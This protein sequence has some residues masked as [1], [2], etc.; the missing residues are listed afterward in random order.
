MPIYE[1]RCN[2]CGHE[3]EEWQKM[4]DAPI[5]TCPKCRARKVEKLISQ[6]SFQLKGSGWYVT[7]YGRK[8][9]AGGSKKKDSTKDAKPDAG[10]GGS[11]TKGSVGGGSSEGSSS[12]SP[13]NGA[14]GAASESASVSARAA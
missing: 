2:A 14:K 3:F 9:S 11:E 5:R 1:Y 12:G 7:D 4:S 10:S 6:S 13:G 8:G